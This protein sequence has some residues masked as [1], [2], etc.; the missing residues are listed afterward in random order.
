MKTSIHPPIQQSTFAALTVEIADRTGKTIQVLPA[1]EF[2]S[3]DG[4]PGNIPGSKTDK[5]VLDATNAAMLIKQARDAKNDR[6][7]DFDHQTLLK[8]GNGKPAP[9][10][11]WY[12]TLEWREGVGLF[13][14]DV[15]WT[16]EA[17]K[18]IASTE[19]KYISPVITFDP[20]TGRITGL[21]MAA[22]TNYAGLD[23]MQPVQLA[24]LSNIFFKQQEEEKMEE[25]LK[26]LRTALNLSATATQ[27]EVVAALTALQA[28]AKAD[29]E[30]VASLS[31]K[32]TESA[33]QIAAL[34][35][36][37]GIPD[38]AKFVPLSAVQELSQ[39][40][41]ALQA[42]VVGGEVDGVVKAALQSGKLLPAL[43][44]WARNLGKTDMAALTAFLDKAPAIAALAGNQ[45]GGSPPGGQP[46]QQG[47]ALV[48]AMSAQF[49]NDPVKVA[50]L[51]AE[52]G[53]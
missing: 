20:N 21:L 17:A 47:D 3:V 35:A 4:R 9:A 7:I 10:A 1:G 22:L 43:E 30:S 15:Q 38:P 48:S 50:A 52:M 5:W 14:I 32:L 27:A 41:L 25:L 53:Q 46:G 8:D 51:L 6:L 33:T 28:K 31:G 36:S 16:A 13:A 42:Q 12:R 40:F 29:A 44:P 37:N 19:Y 34:T 26:L 39:K 23:G 45:T 24:A 2:Q 18:L 11:G 49:G